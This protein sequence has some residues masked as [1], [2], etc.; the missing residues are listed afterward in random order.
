MHIDRHSIPTRKTM[1]DEEWYSATNTARKYGRRDLITIKYINQ[2]TINCTKAAKTGEDMTKS[3]D[4]VSQELQ[5]L[6]FLDC[7]SGVLLNDSG[8]LGPNGTLTNIFKN[9]VNGVFF[10]WHIRA[11]AEMLYRKWQS[12]KIDPHLLW[13]ITTKVGKKGGRNFRVHSFDRDIGDR[14]ISCN[15]SGDG[16]LVNGQWFPFQI[17]ANRDGCHGEIEAGIHGQVYSLNLIDVQSLRAM[18][19]LPYSLTELRTLSS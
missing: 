11:D 15:Y 17:C 19:T 10:P 8:L 5:Q 4:A 7:L 2:L 16:Q 1:H 6:P 14:K 3:F 12:G 9:T 13:G 18:L